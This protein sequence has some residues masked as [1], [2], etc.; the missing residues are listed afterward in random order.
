M[1]SVHEDVLPAETALE[2]AGFPESPET[3]FGLKQAG[4]QA[5][6]YA[7]GLWATRAA[8]LLLVP[9]YTRRLDPAQF[10]IY[11][12]L[13]RTFDV[14]CLVLPAGMVVA[15]MRFY[16]LAEGR[17]RKQVASTAILCPAGMGALAAVALWALR[18]PIASRLLH[19]RSYGSLVLLLGLWVWCELL[20]SIS[21]GLLRARGQA[22]LYTAANVTRSVL[23][24]GLGLWLVWWRDLGL[25]GVMLANVAGSGFAALATAGYAFVSTGLHFSPRYLRS[26]L[27]FGLPLMVTAILSA[28]AGTVDRYL[29]NGYTGAEQVAILGLAAR[30]TMIL[31]VA[32]V[33]PI[34]LTYTPFIFSTVRRKDAQ[35]IFGR[36]RTYMGVLVAGSGLALALFAPELVAVLA[37]A[38]YHSAVKVAR[39]A[40]VASCLYGMS[41]QLE[42]GIYLHGATSWKLPAFATLAGT[43]LAL[44]LALIPRYGAIGAALAQV[45]SQASYLGI[46]YLISERL[47][48]VPYRWS[49]LGKIALAAALPWAAGSGLLPGLPFASP[50]LRALLLAA[51]PVGLWVLRVADA[52]EQARL[53]LSARRLLRMA[54]AMATAPSSSQG[55]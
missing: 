53:R 55:K 19:D 32:T 15:L 27:A 26:F 44:N 29:L 43:S 17:A 4:K 8:G 54:P 21:C 28:S 14:L 23:T 45:G 30:V 41:P 46:L 37:P 5:L 2:Q 49:R 25:P 13:S 33:A 7:A 9:L 20:F 18:E 3:G 1:T 24:I 12:L 39:I 10:G 50:A 48:P 52:E 34:G 38:S 31:G 35:V 47:Y 11:E 51:F 42:I 16:N 40:L 22:A 6:V 36:A